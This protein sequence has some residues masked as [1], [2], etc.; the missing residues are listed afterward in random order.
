[1]TTQFSSF[2][3]T[4]ALTST[5]GLTALS[6]L[7][8]A[9]PAPL[10][11]GEIRSAVS[12]DMCLDANGGPVHNGDNAHLWQ[13]HGQLQQIWYLGTDGALRS[14]KDPTKCLD[15]DNSGTS[16]G[17]N[18]QMWGCNGTDAQKWSLTESGELR[19]AV[20]QD[21]C[22]DVDFAGTSNGTNIQLWECNGTTAQRWTTAKIP[23][24]PITTALNPDQCL[25]VS[26]GSDGIGANVHVWGC[27]GGRNQQWMLTAEGE[28][29]SAVA[30]NRCL[31][32]AA[33]NFSAS[34]NVQYWEC[35]G[36]DAQKWELGA[37]GKLHVAAAPHLCLEIHGDHA[38]DGANA[39][40]WPCADAADQHW[41]SASFVQI[42]LR[43]I[44]GGLHAMVFRS[45]GEGYA[46]V[47]PRT[48]LQL[49]HRFGYSEQAIGDTIDAMSPTQITALYDEYLPQYPGGVSQMVSAPMHSTQVVYGVVITGP[50][51]EAYFKGNANEI[52]ARIGIDLLDIE[53]QGWG[54]TLTGPEIVAF[55][56]VY[57]D[58]VGINAGA[59]LIG[60]SAHVGDPNGTHAGAS[61]GA[62][63][64]L[65]AAAS[66]GHGGQYGATFGIKAVTVEVYVT[67]ADA[68]SAYDTSVDAITQH[69]VPALEGAFWV[70]AQWFQLAHEETN[71]W[72][73]GGVSDYNDAI[74]EA[75][76]A[77]D[78]WAQG[79]AGSVVDWVGSIFG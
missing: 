47:D 7:A 39:Q 70:T 13:C 18:V 12:D 40:L 37:D 16:S 11:V 25:D 66:W 79:T 55:L 57:D 45:R 54:L 43:T 21:R 77:V 1:M 4:T 10:T 5:L 61:A 32:V 41:D 71:A 60:V 9:A 28:V 8:S 53:G 76:A 29:R 30:A 68:H 44:S 49:M 65:E 62:G 78:D 31:D 33:S 67:G 14:A 19:S 38:V 58:G 17:T 46:V 22:L 2:L 35:N 15:V 64:G 20:A 74:D 36:T 26:S 72:I 52:D 6:G 24:A 63:L 51:S 59:S 69:A 42:E 48:L 50:S 23:W 3:A 34:A 73:W 27:H 56:S 75:N